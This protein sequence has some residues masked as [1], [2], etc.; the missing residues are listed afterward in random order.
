M[1]KIFTRQEAIEFLECSE[2]I[3]PQRI[4]E[5]LE[6]RGYTN[7]EKVGRGNK[8][9]F[10]CEFPD[11]T[12][13]Q[14][15]CIFKNILIEEYE[16]NSKL[17]YDLILNIIDFHVNN[18]EFMTIE[19][20][21]KELKMNPKTLY[22]HR[23]KLEGKILKIKEECPHRVMAHDYVLNNIEDITELYYDTVLVAYH[24][25]LDDINK[26]YSKDN[27]CELAIF[28]NKV[29]NSFIT[30]KRPKDEEF[31]IIKKSMNKEGN[32]FLAS[33]PLWIYNE[34]GREMNEWF[35]QKVFQLIL[36]ENGYDYTFFIRLYEVTE[37][38]KNDEEF[39]DFIKRAIKFKNERCD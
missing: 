15:Y 13:E 10:S 7:V 32:K 27:R 19:E 28:R 29:N 23:K 35:K 3:R 8:L 34:E 20:I 30:L 17:N 26:R 37:E 11:D 2:D 5:G 16:Y 36:Q 21:A 18:K 39:L 31:E 25:Y 4:I 33:Y 9:T 6:K 1:K 22:K 38:L 12:D 14:C 24:T